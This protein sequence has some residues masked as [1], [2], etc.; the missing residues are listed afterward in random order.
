[1]NPWTILGW[2][3]V[4]CFGLPLVLMFLLAIVGSANAQ[5]ITI[6]P[7]AYGLGQGMDQYGRRVGHDTLLPGAPLVFTPGVQVRDQFGRPLV[8]NRGHRGLELGSGFLKGKF[9]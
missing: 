1:M 5:Q 3:L 9:E 2:L 7:H 4:L 6:K 8:V